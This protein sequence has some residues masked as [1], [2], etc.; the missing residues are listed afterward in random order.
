MFRYIFVFSIL[1]L[2]PGC[3]LLTPTA[4]LDEEFSLR[5]GEETAI[6]GEELFIKFE[7]VR[8][9]TRCYRSFYDYYIS[10]K[11]CAVAGQARIEASIRKGDRTERLEFLVH[12][13]PSGPRLTDKLYQKKAFL[14]Y[15]INLT[16]LS[17][18]GEKIRLVITKNKGEPDLNGHTDEFELKTE[19][20]DCPGDCEKD[21]FFLE[22]GGTFLHGDAA[23]GGTYHLDIPP[24]KVEEIAAAIADG[25]FFGL[26]D[27]YT[28]EKNCP[29]LVTEKPTIIF[30]VKLNG[31]E[32]SVL[33][34][35][36]CVKNDSHYPVVLFQIQH[37]LKEYSENERKK[38]HEKS[39]GPL[40]LYLRVEVC[41]DEK[42][43]V[44]LISV[45]SRVGGG[46]IVSLEKEDRE[47]E[48]NRTY[49]ASHPFS[50]TD[51]AFLR[52]KI[53]GA[54]FL[55]ETS[56]KTDLTVRQKCSD[57]RRLPVAEMT[58][59]QKDGR[60]TVRHYL[61]C[62]DDE[63]VPEALLEIEEKLLEIVRLKEII[64]KP[65]PTGPTRSFS[66][67]LNRKF[68]IS[69]GEKAIFKKENLS[70]TFI[71]VPAD[72]RCPFDQNVDCGQRGSAD[73]L[74]AVEK[75][76]KREMMTL[77]DNNH[78]SPEDAHLRFETKTFQ[79]YRIHLKDVP[80]NRQYRIT[81]LVTKM[82]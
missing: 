70:I 3:S 16:S 10:G 42:C 65:E 8:E 19:V 63:T 22:R 9:D 14:N 24:D 51:T 28:Q 72:N 57:P 25:G 27:E 55:S 7:A 35:Q 81:L 18:N 61:N 67:R 2:L 54:D 30:S 43:P 12:G 64:P 59:N 41:R 46:Q 74:L 26:E 80:R 71:S 79:N 37:K 68:Q 77:K 49:L 21:I 75:G 38:A 32:K 34:D 60:Q 6:A 33:Y 31:G 13:N 29:D 73:I 78:Y 76:N 58:I 17:L 1:L 66:A 4:D 44:Y 5:P 48:K 36:G 39:A 50:E 52:E 15:R 23:G 69:V 82:E 62:K 20:I 56:P 47:P 11:M 40:N 45:K 53:A